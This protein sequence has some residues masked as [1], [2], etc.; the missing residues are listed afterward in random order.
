[1]FY[2]YYVIISLALSPGANF[3]LS[4][5]CALLFRVLNRLRNP[6]KPYLFHLLFPNLSGNI[7]LCKCM[8]LHLCFNSDIHFFTSCHSQCKCNSFCWNSTLLQ[9]NHLI[10]F[11]FFPSFFLFVYVFCAFG[12]TGVFSF[13]VLR[14]FFSYWIL[15]HWIFDLILHTFQ[16]FWGLWIYLIEKVFL[17]W[18][19]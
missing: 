9:P 13:S 11:I 2:F 18:T 5:F 17:G 14:M 4:W 16:R 7:L 10:A 12:L 8:F 1:M 15:C 3:K 6:L 19:L